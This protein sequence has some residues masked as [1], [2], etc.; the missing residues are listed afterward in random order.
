MADFQ[1]G[2]KN[3]GYRNAFAGCGRKGKMW[4]YGARDGEPNSVAETSERGE[5]FKIDPATHMKVIEAAGVGW[6]EIM[7]AF[8]RR[9]DEGLA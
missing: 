8:G 6:W 1:N 4:K 5:C 2:R 7:R 3:L 9:V